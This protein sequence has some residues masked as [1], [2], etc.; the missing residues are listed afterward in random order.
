V[1][2]AQC[3]QQVPTLRRRVLALLWQQP[4]G[5]VPESQQRALLVQVLQRLALPLWARA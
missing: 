5:R 3:P 2:L 1:Q 4:Q